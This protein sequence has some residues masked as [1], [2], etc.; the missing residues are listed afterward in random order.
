VP[1]TFVPV[2]EASVDGMDA[3]LIAGIGAVVIVWIVISGVGVYYWNRARREH[4]EQHTQAVR[5]P[6]RP[7]P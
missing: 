4:Q 7:V 5:I 3:A 6:T 1:A 2:A